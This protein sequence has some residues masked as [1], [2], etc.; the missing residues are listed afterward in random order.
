MHIPNSGFASIIGEIMN[1]RARPAGSRSADMSGVGASAVN[2]TPD[3][4]SVL[5]ATTK[6]GATMP[7]RSWASQ[8]CLR[9]N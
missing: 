8:W 2:T 4:R 9:A 6:D 7:F 5:M 1:A 3:Q